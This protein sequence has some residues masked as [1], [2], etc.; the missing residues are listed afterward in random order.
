MTRGREGHGPQGEAPT[1][2]FSDRVSDYAR[3]RPS[4]PAEAVAALVEGVPLLSA[5]AD[6]WAAD[7]GAGTGIS[8]RLLLERGFLVHAVEPNAAMRG[9]GEVE[10]A[11][12]GARVRWHGTTGEAT[13]LADAS[14][15][16]VL[17]A[18]S[19][20]WMEGSAAVREFAR[21][22]KPGGKAAA[23]WNVHDVRDPFM[24]GYRDVVMRHARDVPRSPWFRND[25]CVLGSRAAVDAG[26]VGYV[27]R[28]FTNE[29]EVTLEGLIGRAMSASYMPARGAERVPAE[30]DLA[31]LF[32]RF[33][34]GG[35]VAMRYVCEVHA[36]LRQG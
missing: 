20:H 35:V 21:V 9:R 1:E 10:T 31:G 33:E 17:C 34:R 6:S 24:A 30:R 27:L 12:F 29:H 25:A 11:G 15:S 2:R 32:A 22:L 36:S 7:I 5:G 3:H 8:T 18:Q 16:L 14:V 28:E 23:V 13:G 4:Y 19:L 26:L